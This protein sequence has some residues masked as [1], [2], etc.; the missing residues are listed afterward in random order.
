MLLAEALALRA[1]LQVRLKELGTRIQANAR[2]PAGAAPDEDPRRLL[3]EA[4]AV[5]EELTALVRRV[6][7]TNALVV[8]SPEAPETVSDLIAERDR[9][10]R[11]TRVFRDAAQAATRGSGRGWLVQDGEGTYATLDVPELQKEGD[12]WAARYRELDVRLQRLN[13]SVDVME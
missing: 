6:N 9:A 2:V 4:A 8:A 11:M 1:D 13:W 12:R 10:Q 3:D 7:R 5:S